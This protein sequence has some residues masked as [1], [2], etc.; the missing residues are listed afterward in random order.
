[1]PPRKRRQQELRK[2]QLESQRP[3]TPLELAESYVKQELCRRSRMSFFIRGLSLTFFVCAAMTIFFHSRAQRSI[4]ES[5]STGGGK[6]IRLVVAIGPNPNQIPKLKPLL[7]S[8]LDKQGSS[9]PSMLYLVLARMDS[10]HAPLAYT[11]PQYIKDY[12]EKRRIIILRP[13]IGF[14]NATKLYAVL[15]FERT[16]KTSRILSLDATHEPVPSNYI[17]TW[18]KLA[19]KLPNA[20]LGFQGATLTS[21][22]RNL[23]TIAQVKEPTKVDI[24]EGKAILVQRRFFN[25]EGLKEVVQEAPPAMQLADRFLLSAH[26]EEQN[27]ERWVVPFSGI[28]KRVEVGRPNYIQCGYYL[29]QRLGIWKGFKF[30]NFKRLTQEE[31]DAISC[32]NGIQTLCRDGYLEILQA[33]DSKGVKLVK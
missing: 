20:A 26:L 3:L 23:N 31:K 4:Q 1:M 14:G 21:Y 6:R 8:L 18:L 24:L 10:K 25:P 11:I 16:A 7:N 32:D 28:R 17:A 22:Y 13:N 2:Q 19:E 29:Q 27:V 9:R 15:R 5:S 30:H 12:I 33:L